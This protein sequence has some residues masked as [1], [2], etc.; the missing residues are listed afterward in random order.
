MI[1]SP[2]GSPKRIL[3]TSLLCITLLLSA[4]L[5]STSTQLQHPMVT[6]ATDLSLQYPDASQF[7]LNGDISAQ[8]LWTFD[9]AK[10]L[11][12]SSTE[13]NLQH[14]DIRIVDEGDIQKEVTRVTEKLVREQFDRLDY[15][16][17]FLQKIVADQQG[18]YAALYIDGERNVLVNRSLMQAY[19]NSL[20]QARDIY[21][22]LLA[23]LIHE[24][25]HAAD[26]VNYGIHKNRKLNFKTSFTQSATFEGHAQFVTRKICLIH[27]CLVGMQALERF[28]FE[29]T[30]MPDPVAQSVQAIS[31]NVLEY[32]YIEG[33]RFLTELSK[34]KDGEKLIAEVLTNPPE[35]PVQIL[36]PES[37]PNTQRERA[38]KQLF[39]TLGDFEHE[40]T[41]APW[42]LV[43][44]SPIK[45]I[46][47]R[48]APERRVAAIEGFTQ[49]ITAMTGAQLYNQDKKFLEPIDIMLIKAENKSTARLFAE[50]FVNRAANT[51]ALE[52][53][54]ASVDIKRAENIG[55]A[56][57]SIYLVSSML[58]DDHMRR[59]A[60]A[61]GLW[62]DYVVQISA[63][64]IGT[65]TVLQG[66][67]YGVMHNF[68][69]S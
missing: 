25:V 42:K 41:R 6:A 3:R 57:Y 18:T 64:I 58:S 20:A 11:V 8:L 4:C 45:G 65:D 9:E 27:N 30:Q 63:R 37:Y 39:A 59:S 21:P 29:T 38:N 34:R 26:D 62:N 44:T 48:D 50:S 2:F 15:A 33:E 31:R 22:A 7:P 60:V 61:I 52:T 67:V 12:E 32:S 51:I 43:E 55:T 23:L 14:V 28:M 36:V 10:K 13:T 16:Q 1:L 19:I 24:L 49:L 56:A 5:P 35:D 68:S 40:W 69:E 47:V 54:D 17:F 66:Y 46:D 53:G